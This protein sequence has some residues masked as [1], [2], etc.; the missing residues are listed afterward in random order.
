[1]SAILRVTVSDD[2]GSNEFDVDLGSQSLVSDP[3][4]ITDAVERGIYRAEGSGW[5]YAGPV[6]ITVERVS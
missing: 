6:T 5:S 3:R 1:M 2:A 4:M